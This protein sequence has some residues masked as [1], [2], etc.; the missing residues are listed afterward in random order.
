MVDLQPVISSRRCWLAAAAAAVLVLLGGPGC[1]Q[2]PTARAW[3]SYVVEVEKLLADHDA[4]ML[5]I[6]NVNLALNPVPNMPAPKQPLTPGEAAE[7]VETK[8]IP[9]LD[10]VAARAG[11]IQIPSS[12]E[13]TRMHAPLVE[14]LAGKAEAYKWMVKGFKGRSSADF[15]KGMD[16]LSAATGKLDGFRNEFYEAKYAGGPRT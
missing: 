15:Q 8:V 13:L 9:M 10:S 12:P 11:G 3:P 6:A 4:A 14:G 16:Q 1:S 5:E 2:D 7:A